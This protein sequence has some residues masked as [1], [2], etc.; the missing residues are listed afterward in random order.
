MEEAVD[1][2]RLHFDRDVIVVDR[3]RIA[4]SLDG[5]RLSLRQWL[6]ATGG[7]DAGGSLVTR[8][9]IRRRGF[10]RHPGAALVA[11]LCVVGEDGPAPRAIL[12]HDVLLLLGYALPVRMAMGRPAGRDALGCWLFDLMVRRIVCGCCAT[13]RWGEMRHAGV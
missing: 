10:G 3:D 12:R 13:S 2:R 1:S 7:G 9:A 4:V 8:D 11:E 5:H 6:G